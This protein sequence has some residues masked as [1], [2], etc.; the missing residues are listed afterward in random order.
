[1]V[2]VLLVN[3][4]RTTSIAPDTWSHHRHMQAAS[5][6][7]P[8]Y[9]P[10]CDPTH[11]QYAMQ[12]Y[13]IRDNQ[14]APPDPDNAFD[15]HNRAPMCDVLGARQRQWL[16][17]ALRKHAEVKELSYHQCVLLGLLTIAVFLVVLSP[18]RL[19]H[20]PFASACVVHDRL[21]HTVYPQA[22]LHLVVSG[23]VVLGRPDGTNS[24]SDP[25]GQ[26][27]GDDFECYRPAQAALLADVAAAAAEVWMSTQGAVELGFGGCN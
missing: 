9:G 3:I 19:S 8:L 2:A 26:C 5:Q 6:R 16:K 1:M 15:F 20:M 21:H 17:R 27:S 10:V 18:W 24:K 11:P 13:V 4:T 22:P 12:P 23:S 7:H 14:P 25:R